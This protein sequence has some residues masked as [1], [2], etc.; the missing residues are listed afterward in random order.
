MTLEVLDSVTTTMDAA[1]DNLIAGR[2][3]FDA[4]G[5]PR[6][7]CGVIASEQPAGRGQRGRTWYGVS[8]ESLCP[9]Y[10]LRHGIASPNRAPLLSLLSGVAAADA[11]SASGILSGR[12]AT[13]PT[14]LSTPAQLGLKWPND[15]LVDQKKVGGILVEMVR[16]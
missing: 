5:H 12:T 9:T 8:G 3:R 2:V 7:Y 15:I 1:R 4:P 14:D 11:I 10:Y 13:H 6:P 16:A